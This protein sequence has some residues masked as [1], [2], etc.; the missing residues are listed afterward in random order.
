MAETGQWQKKIIK[1]KKLNHS[2]KA[3][4]FDT[5]DTLIKVFIVKAENPQKLDDQALHKLRIDCKKLRYTT[6]FF[7]SLHHKTTT[8]T[9][10][11]K[12]KQ[13]QDSLGDIHDT[14]IQK[15]LHQRLLQNDQKI[16]VT[17]ASQQ[18]LVQIDRAADI[19]KSR[20]IIQ[21]TAFCHTEYPWHT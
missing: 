13:L 3:F 20:I 4:A 10:V 8:R 7:I 11:E 14:F 15:K 18:V 9:F 5:L 21:L 12:L 19:K 16:H 17:P 2:L 6:E 1:D